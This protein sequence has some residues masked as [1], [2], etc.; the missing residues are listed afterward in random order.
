MPEK[1]ALLLRIHS[2]LFVA[3]IS[4]PVSQVLPR[5]DTINFIDGFSIP[6]NY[7]GEDS[8]YVYYE[9]GEAKKKLSRSPKD[10]IFSIVFKNGEE[11]IYYVPPVYSNYKPED[12]RAYFSGMKDGNEKYFPYL[13]VAS[14]V[15]WSFAG[16]F[17]LAR[18]PL[19][20]LV[21]WSYSLLIYISPTSPHY[22]LWREPTPEPSELYEIGFTT[23][24]KNKKTK[25]AIGISLAFTA[26]G[27]VAGNIYRNNLGY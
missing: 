18:N 6:A 9:Y 20:L 11:N 23:C 10:E 4:M 2:I 22:G 13:V 21:P 17:Y 24:V 7:I 25:I 8:Q 15:I 5:M 12:Y 3:V 19:V 16:G 27:I 1:Q 26:L 14:G